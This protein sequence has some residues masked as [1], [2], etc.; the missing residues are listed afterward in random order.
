[1]T[2]KIMLTHRHYSELI[3][4]AMNDWPGWV[5]L[6]PMEGVPRRKLTEPYSRPNILADLEKAGLVSLTLGKN[7]RTATIRLTTAGIEA[8]CTMP[9]KLPGD[10]FFPLPQDITAA[11]D[12]LGCAD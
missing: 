1:M 3:R 7:N 2:V 8:I 4:A 12:R 9:D 10:H 11:K 6:G 5:P